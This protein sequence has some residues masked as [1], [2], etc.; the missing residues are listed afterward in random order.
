[1]NYI[2]TCYTST[3]QNNE[4]QFQDIWV[5]EILYPWYESTRG[6]PQF[7]YAYN[8]GIDEGWIVTINPN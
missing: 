8:Q 6:T 2:E 3:N 7:E 1:M 5:Q 4:W